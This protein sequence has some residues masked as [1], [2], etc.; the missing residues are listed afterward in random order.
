MIVLSLFRVKL[1]CIIVYSYYYTQC[2]KAAVSLIMF[3][4]DITINDYVLSFQDHT[5]VGCP[6][7]ETKPDIQLQG[8][9]IQPEHCVVDITENE[10]FVSP[11]EGAR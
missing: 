5:L 10:V 6:N 3:Q 8:L 1:S 2:V 7:E 4:T 11:V 9:G